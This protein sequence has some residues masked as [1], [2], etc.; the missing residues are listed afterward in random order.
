MD[1]QSLVLIGTEHQIPLGPP[2]IAA[3]LICFKGTYN[4]CMSNVRNAVPFT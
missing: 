1:I 4:L 3:S 2:Q